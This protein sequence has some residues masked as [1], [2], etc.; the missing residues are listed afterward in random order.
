[1]KTTSVVPPGRV[2]MRGVLARH[3][4]LA[5]GAIPT[6][7]PFT[8]TSR[9]TSPYPPLQVGIACAG[10]SARSA[11]AAPVSS[12]AWIIARAAELAAMPATPAT[13]PV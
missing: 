12:A 3:A 2:R 8:R 4:Q 5:A 13:G 7:E 11:F 6:A 1:M 10:S 9:R